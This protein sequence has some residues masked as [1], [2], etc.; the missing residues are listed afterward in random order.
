MS[1]KNSLYLKG[2]INHLYRTFCKQ[3]DTMRLK[4]SFFTVISSLLI[5][6]GI[7]AKAAEIIYSPDRNLSVMFTIQEKY[8]YLLPGER[9]YFSLYYQDK[10]IVGDSPLG[11]DIEGA[12]ALGSDLR[13]FNVQNQYIKD[14][15]AY[16]TVLP[17]TTVIEYNKIILHLQEK[18]PP[19][20]FFTVECIVHNQG[21]ALR[22]VMPSR[23][24]IS[25]SHISRERTMIFVD[26][27]CKIQAMDTEA[28]RT[29]PV[30]LGSVN[31]DSTLS[32]PLQVTSA[33]GPVLGIFESAASGY[34]RSS[35]KRSGDFSNALTVCLDT[36]RQKQPGTRATSWRIFMT[37]DDPGMFAY[38]GLFKILYKNHVQ[39]DSAWIGHGLYAD[40]AETGSP[41]SIDSI[42][43]FCSGRGVKFLLLDDSEATPAVCSAARSRSITPLV[44]VSFADMSGSSE[45]FLSGLAEK[46]AGGVL[47]ECSTRP[48]ITSVDRIF[49]EAGS[50]RLITG[51]QTG[52][53]LSGLS[54]LHH[55]FVLKQPPPASA[56]PDTVMRNLPAVLPYTAMAGEPVDL[57]SAVTAEYAADSAPC[58]NAALHIASTSMLRKYHPGISLENHEKLMGA[59]Q[60][61]PPIWHETRFIEGGRGQ[62]IIVARRH[63]DTWYVAGFSTAASK[64]SDVSLSFLGKS[65]L[66]W[67]AVIFFDNPSASSSDSLAVISKQADVT[68]ADSLP[69]I[70][71]PQKGYTAVITP[72]G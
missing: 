41:R 64:T 71:N 24:D 58:W 62:Y 45:K 36:D 2:N 50:H 35:L 19:F 37:G 16:E 32:M 1:G 38:S 68:S 5:F 22:Y 23:S 34:G 15:V 60:N 3:G 11:L 33:T 59:V 9:L 25:V 8:S 72:A 30:P 42:L 13:L 6:S 56:L 31:R 40:A 61:I 55:H 14:T 10:E 43:D 28:Y 67:N 44:R 63:A 70:L 52:S 66:T 49:S 69:V 47:L 51:I 57:S 20:R 18:R 53:S 54:A 65:G 12:P 39:S 26:R 21:A 7:T 27:Q 46:G 48:D 29:G 17:D 4:I